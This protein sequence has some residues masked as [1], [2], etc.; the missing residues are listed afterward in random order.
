MNYTEINLLLS[1]STERE[2]KNMMESQLGQFPQVSAK[3]IGLYFETVDLHTYQDGR[4][5][6]GLTWWVVT[7]FFQADLDPEL[8]ADFAS[9]AST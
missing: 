3:L 7:L 1:A 5:Q 4:L 6:P 9:E 8:L 2:A